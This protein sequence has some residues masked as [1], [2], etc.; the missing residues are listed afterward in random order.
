MKVSILVFS[1][2][3]FALTMGVACAGTYSNNDTFLNVT[4]IIEPD[5]GDTFNVTLMVKNI[6]PI[7]KI[8][9]PVYVVLALDT[10]GTMKDTDKGFVKTKQAVK[11][12]LNFFEE[13]QVEYK[14]AIV[15]WD[16]NVDYNTSFTGNRQEI[17]TSLEKLRAEYTE[18]TEYDYAIIPSVKLFMDTPNIPENAK[19]NCY[20]CYRC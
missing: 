13:Y 17:E 12:L 4:K 2:I 7:T 6:Q 11:T 10:S 16:S 14:I 9:Y 18:P 20:Y 3:L 15:S 19:K 8:K 1:G 5:V